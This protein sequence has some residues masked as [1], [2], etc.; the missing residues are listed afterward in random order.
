MALPISVPYSFANATTSIPL[1]QLDTDIST[2]YATVN[3]IGNGT[4]ALSNVVITGGIVSNVSGISTSAISNGTSNVSIATANGNVVVSTAGNTAMT[5]DTSQNMTAVGTVAMASSFKRNRII[6]GNMLIDQRNAGASITPTSSNVYTVD[7]WYEGQSQASKFSIQQNAGAVTPPAGFTN[8]LGVTSLSAY[9]LTS[10]DFFDIRQAIEGP[11]AGDLAFGTANAKT[12]TLSFY[13]YSSLT[14]TFGGVFRNYGGSRFY[15]FS[16]TISTANTWTSV[17]ITIA[18][19]TSGT[20]TTTASNGWGIVAFSFGAGTTYQGTAGAWSGTTYTS[21]TGQTN[22][23]GTNG[24]TFYITGVQLEVGTKATP[25]E[26]QIYSDQLAQCQRYYEKSYSQGTVSGTITSSGRISIGTG[27]TVSAQWFFSN[28]FKIT[29]RANPTVSTWSI[30]AANT[31]GV[32]TQDNGVDVSSTISN[33]NDSGFDLTWTNGASRWG[34]FYQFT[35][36][37][38]L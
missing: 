27:A 9:S 21:C 11:N 17:S 2:I 37:A 15:P 22:V 4:V 23:V 10:T 8:Y 26:M 20:W 13:V 5:V 30:A 36:S 38:E 16:Y 28:T 14:G 7:R 18:G 6:N 33:T 24:A 3:G 31:S 19:D 12:V 32:V 1:S 35:A 34:G 25:Y 29:K